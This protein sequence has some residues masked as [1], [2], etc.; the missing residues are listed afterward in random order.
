[1]RSLLIKHDAGQQEAAA[2]AIEAVKSSNREAITSSLNTLDF[3]GGAGSI[4]DLILTEMPWT[5][6]FRRDVADDSRLTMLELDLV[7]EMERLGIANPGVI[8]R[9]AG[10]QFSAEYWGLL[11]S[12]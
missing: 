9:R 4:I 8:A 7:N 3:W 1:M 6:E 10:I 5:A 11:P 2:Q 12:E